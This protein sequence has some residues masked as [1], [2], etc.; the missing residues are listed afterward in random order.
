MARKP[1]VIDSPF[2]TQMANALVRQYGK[3]NAEAT[4][5]AEKELVPAL[6]G[7]SPSTSIETILDKLDAELADTFTDEV[8]ESTATKAAAGFERVHQAAFYTK[9]SHIMGATI[10]G[11]DTPVVGGKP[12]PLRVYSGLIQS[13]GKVPF[14]AQAKRTYMVPISVDPMLF[15]SEFVDQNVKLMKTLRGGI[16]Q[17]MADQI[18][19]EVFFGTGDPVDL[20]KRIVRKWKKNGVPSMFTFGK[21]VVSA[22]S[23]AALIARDQLAKLN[24]DL[25][26]SRQMAAGIRSFNWAIQGDGRVRASHRS[27]GSGGPYD[28]AI[29]H[30]SLGY[31]GKPI[32]CRCWARAVIVPSEIEANTN[33]IPMDGMPPGISFN[34]S[35][36]T[37]Q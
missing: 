17:G 20:Q 37:G 8:I 18:A 9:L 36:L 32:A 25:T 27:A 29:G 6:A 5:I 7:G 21:R 11:S 13:R 31:P 15:T 24:A 3:L 28:W 26:R 30:P 10:L 16:R 23:H 33:L 1:N 34:L 14:G 12:R 35:G 2:P 4:R 19:R 22:E